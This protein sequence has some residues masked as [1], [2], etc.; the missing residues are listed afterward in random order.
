MG[1]A[2]FWVC[3]YF[4]VEQLSVWAC[5]IMDLLLNPTLIMLQGSKV[6]EITKCNLTYLG[7]DSDPT[8]LPTSASSS[9]YCFCY[10]AFFLEVCLLFQDSSETSILAHNCW[11]ISVNGVLFR[12]RT[13]FIYV[14]C[15]PS[16][17]SP[18]SHRLPPSFPFCSHA[19][20]EPALEHKLPS[21]LKS[22]CLSLPGTGIRRVCT[23]VS[24]VEMF[25]IALK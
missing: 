20:L 23:I 1:R 16:P 7:T 5:M 6:T 9:C 17:P 13:L 24:D 4:R 19:G 22:T 25:S 15:V 3:F 8:V 12:R 14:R 2:V 11:F 18:L 10:T 21:N